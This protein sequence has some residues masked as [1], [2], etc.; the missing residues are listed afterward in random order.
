MKRKISAKEI[1][2]P[3]VSLF[4]I[5]LVVT[6]LLA[7]TDKF[8]QPQIEKLAIETENK[9][10]AEVLTGADSFSDAKTYEQDGVTYEYYEGMCNGSMVGY[11][12]STSAKGYGGDIDVMVGI[13]TDGLVQGVSIL[14]ISETAGLG[15]NAKN[16][17]FLTQFKGRSGE[18]GVA[19]NN[20]SESE[21]QALT[22]ATITSKAMAAAVNTALAIYSEIGGES[23][24]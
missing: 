9:T 16:E 2:V 17:S 1:I 10:K 18:I 12:F 19:K 14:S 4:L 13:G 24:G 6:A 20:P 3:A 15:M 23:N 8:T 11:V 7:V 21:I 22:G 5:C